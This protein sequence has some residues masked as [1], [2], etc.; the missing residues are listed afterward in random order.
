VEGPEDAPLKEKAAAVAAE[1][2]ALFAGLAFNKILMKIWE[3]LD[4]ANLYIND[5]GPWRL[6]KSDA[7]K[8]RLHT[9]LYNAAEALRIA[10]VLIHPFMPESAEKIRQQIGHAQKAEDDGLASLAH[11]GGLAAGAVTQPGAQLFPRIEEK[12]AQTILES[13][14]ANAP[15]A[16]TAA[17]DSAKK[18]LENL[19]EPVTIED[20]MKLDLRTGIVLQAEKVP[21]SK[22]LLKLKVDIG[23]EE[24]QVV[25]GISQSYEPEQLVG[26]TVILVANLKPAKLMGIES[27]GMIL[28]GSNGDK[29]VL[30]GFDQDLGRGSQVK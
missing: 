3:F 12:Q 1:V 19:K 18:E 5:T 2:D 23:M 15:A 9:V 16:S 7:G 13:L 6:A 8:K 4:A 14:D 29:I 26:R 20:F 28:A 27:Q 22:K 24:R 30:A 10:S 21:K 25:A 17:P 11:W